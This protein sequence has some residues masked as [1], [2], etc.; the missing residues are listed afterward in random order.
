MPPHAAQLPRWSASAACPPQ[1]VIPRLEQPRRASTGLPQLLGA[2]L[3]RPEL[4]LLAP[5]LLFIFA[6]Y[7]LLATVVQTG[8]DYWLHVRTGQYIAESGAVPRADLYSYTIAGQPWVAHEWLT[9]L[10]L[11]FVQQRFGYVGN[12]L[13]FGL[14]GTLTALA[15]YATCRLLGWGRWAPPC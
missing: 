2:Q 4:L 6:S 14:I 12:V 3:V 7:C 11:Y 15:V 10:L 9:E 8:P 13:L 1:G 5:M